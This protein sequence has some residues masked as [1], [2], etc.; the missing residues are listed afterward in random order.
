[1]KNPVVSQIAVL[2]SLGDLSYS[3]AIEYLA[4]R[5]GAPEDS[6]RTVLVRHLT[7]LGG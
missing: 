6:V 3:E 5:L 1:M 7:A 4:R 2:I